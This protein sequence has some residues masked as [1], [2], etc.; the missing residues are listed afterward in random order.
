[1]K[2]ICLLLALIM[3]L[4]CTVGCS[5]SS[6]ES[7]TDTVAE[8]ETV[9]KGSEEST[10]TEDTESDT[11]SDTADVTIDTSEDDEV[12]TDTTADTSTVTVVVTDKVTTASETEKKPVVTEAPTTKPAVTTKKEEEKPKEDTTG[13]VTLPVVAVV[14]AVSISKSVSDPDAFSTDNPRHK[15]YVPKLNMSSEN[16]LKFNA[17]IY[18]EFF[19]VCEAVQSGDDYN[20]RFEIN[21]KYKTYDGLVGI[22]ISEMGARPATC[23]YLRYICFYYDMK[24]DKELTFDEY[25]VS[26]GFTASSLKRRLKNMEALDGKSHTNVYGDVIGCAVGE[27]MAY[28]AFDDYVSVFNVG[29]Y[30]VGSIFE[31]AF[32]NVKVGDYITFGDYE[33]DN[34][35]SNGKEDIEW[36]VL[37]I[38]GSKALIISKYAL[39]A[40]PYNTEPTEVTWET[41]TLRQWLNNDF[42]NT[43]FT[44]DERSK[45]VTT[46]VTAE[47]NTTYDT[48]AGND[49]QDRIFLLSI[50]EVNKYESAR[51][52]K[53]TEY[54]IAN[55]VYVEKFNDRYY[56]NC[57]C[58]LL[59]S[60]GYDQ[61][62][63]ACVDYEGDVDERGSLVD[64]SYSAF[65]PALWINIES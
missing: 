26:L 64:F 13:T 41:C 55:G 31:S 60:P 6:S 44:A 34:N 18:S 1:M 50:N 46:K 62:C 4:C 58:W 45:V 42:L 3:V 23:G 5:G 30:A 38:R 8:S 11:T 22:I 54:A 35:I 51:Q 14:D 12:P 47:D 7:G 19:K 32:K 56:G 49:T 57:W 65:R 25:A 40:K 15:I 27:S 43:A 39:D 28:V 9:T 21:Y 20:Y 61:F 53:A 29:D 33:Q 24:N 36:L 17:K 2:K 16:A 10:P 63:T 37:D 52:C 48:D 59:R